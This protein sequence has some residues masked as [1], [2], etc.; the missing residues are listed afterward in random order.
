M[1]V[2]TLRPHLQSA[3]IS[4]SMQKRLL[5]KIDYVCQIPFVCVW[6]GDAGGGGEGAGSFLAGSLYL[7]NIY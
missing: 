2:T 4:Y 5:F 7:I 3:N 1:A 6:G